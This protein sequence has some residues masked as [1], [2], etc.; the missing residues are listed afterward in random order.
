MQM[1]KTAFNGLNH[2]LIGF[3]LIRRR[4]V[5]FYVLTPLLINIL[6]FSLLFAISGHY[7]NIFVQWIE[8]LLPSWLAWLAVILWL[9]FGIACIVSLGFLFTIIA[10]FIAAPFNSLLAEKVQLMI[11]GELP[12]SAKITV[13][14]SL[15][16]L[17]SILKRECQKLLYVLPRAL[18][19]LILFWIPV[20]GLIAPFLWFMFSAWCVAMEYVDY[21][22]DNNLVK[23]PAMKQRLRQHKSLNLGFGLATLGLTMLPIVNLFVMPAAIAGA[24]HLWVIHYKQDF[25]IA[26]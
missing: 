1:S 16:L 18:G 25:K 23:F 10:T 9:I 2:L 12:P 26:T 19:F 14:S 24:T 21:P 4:E 17:P 13:A 15:K 8:S 6:T 7:F 5:R 20:V 3:Q 11:T 22:M